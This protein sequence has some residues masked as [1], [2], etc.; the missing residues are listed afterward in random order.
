MSYRRLLSG[1][2]SDDKSPDPASGHHT[3]SQT[4]FIAHVLLHPRTKVTILLMILILSLLNLPMSIIQLDTRSCA[5]NHST[6]DTVPTTFTQDKEFQSLDRSFDHLWAEL[7]M[8]KTTAGLIYT[9]EKGNRKEQGGISMF[10]QLHCLMM[11]RQALQAASEGEAIG[12][13]WHDDGHWPHCMDY[14]VKV[15]ITHWSYSYRFVSKANYMR[16]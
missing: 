15:A 6:E 4:T 3:N 5:S 11:M 12:K 2:F 1:E 8:N 14:L 13:D 10:H 16:S 9:A 7:S